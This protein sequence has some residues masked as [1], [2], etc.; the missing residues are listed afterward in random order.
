[1]S[2]RIR[3][4]KTAADEREKLFVDAYYGGDEDGQAVQLTIGGQYVQ[5]SQDQILDLVAVLTRRVK[6]GDR[7]MSATGHTDAKT[8]DPDGSLTV[9]GEEVL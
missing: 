8:V 1:M 6:R 5:L 2:D 3:T 9:E 7:T 4:Y